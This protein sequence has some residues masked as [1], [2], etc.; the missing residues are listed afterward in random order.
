MKA[1]F[2]FQK[3]LKIKWFQNWSSSMFILEKKKK[4]ILIKNMY[5]Y[6]KMEKLLFLE[7]ATQMNNQM[8]SLLSTIL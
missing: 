6:R 1:L 2:P 7:I 4:D 5:N 8:F 3:L